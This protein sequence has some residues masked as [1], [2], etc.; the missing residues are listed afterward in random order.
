ML[1]RQLLFDP[2]PP[3]RPHRTHAGLRRP[4]ARPAAA[5]ALRRRS[6]SRRPR[7][8]QPRSGS[9]S[10]S[11]ATTGS[12]NAMY[13]IVLFIVER[14]FNGFLGSGEIPRSAVERM[15]ATSASGM[16][17]VN[18]THSERSRRSAQSDEIVE[19]IARSDQRES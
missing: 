11:K 4:S 2:R 13:S 18:V 5:P 7:H 15:A 12:P 3:C 9:R 14:S 16:R 10:R 17:P 1:P 6:V 19:A 8:L